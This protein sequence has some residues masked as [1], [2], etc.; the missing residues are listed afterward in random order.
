MVQSS[1]W[2]CQLH[3]PSAGHVACNAEIVWQLAPKCTFCSMPGRCLLQQNQTRESADRGP[4]HCL[5]ECRSAQC[6]NL[7]ASAPCGIQL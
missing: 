2:H 1:G 7:T 6:S 5:P 3:L 4:V